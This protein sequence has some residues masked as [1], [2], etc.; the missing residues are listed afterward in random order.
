MEILR[1]LRRG[2]LLFQI[3][4]IYL[5]NPHKSKGKFKDK[6]HLNLRCLVQVGPDGINNKLL[7]EGAPF[8][9]EHLKLLFTLSLQ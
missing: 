8:L 2:N 1:S 5:F 9:A 6:E 7:K 3:T 4:M